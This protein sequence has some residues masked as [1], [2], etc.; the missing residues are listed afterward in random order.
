MST[1]KPRTRRRLDCASELRTRQL[2]W[3]RLTFEWQ[4]PGAYF[5]LC[6]HVGSAHPWRKTKVWPPA[7]IDDLEHARATSDPFAHVAEGA[8]PLFVRS[9]RYARVLETPVVALRVA[10]EMIASR[11]AEQTFGHLRTEL[12]CKRTRC[13]IR[14]D[15][16]SLLARAGEVGLSPQA[17]RLPHGMLRR[18]AGGEEG[19]H[20]REEGEDGRRMLSDVGDRLSSDDCRRGCQNPSGNASTS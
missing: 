6:N 8:Q 5:A 14:R 4:P 2:G 9:P 10:R 17:A 18:R 7:S 3:W 16:Y 15:P 13:F 12:W 20:A 19:R 11:V 1:P